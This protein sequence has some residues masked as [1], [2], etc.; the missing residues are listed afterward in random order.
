VNQCLD[1]GKKFKLRD[2]TTYL[3]VDLMDR[4]FLSGE[5]KVDSSKRNL[6]LY[7][8]TCV[9]VAAKYDELD[10]NIPLISDL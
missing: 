7:Q 9:L 1:M 6:V 10:E 5:M 3:A 8:L 4:L 2:E